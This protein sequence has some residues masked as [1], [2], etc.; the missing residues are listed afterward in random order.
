MRSPALEL[1]PEKLQILLRGNIM[2]NRLLKPKSAHKI[3]LA[4]LCNVKTIFG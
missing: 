4:S 1:G 3:S 2:D